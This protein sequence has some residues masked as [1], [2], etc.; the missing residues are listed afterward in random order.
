MVQH[1]YMKL[2]DVTGPFMEREK[3]VQEVITAH[4]IGDVEKN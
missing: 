3:A 1:K 2:M 4:Q